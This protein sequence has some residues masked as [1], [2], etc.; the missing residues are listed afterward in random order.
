MIKY[1]KPIVIQNEE[2]EDEAV[3]AGGC[4]D[5]SSSC[6]AAVHKKGATGACGD[7]SSSCAA[8]VHK[9]SGNSSCGDF[10]SSCGHKVHK[11]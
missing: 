10:S 1:E 8:A 5:Y 7:Y 6:G 4:G 9:K 3:F 2:N 11:K